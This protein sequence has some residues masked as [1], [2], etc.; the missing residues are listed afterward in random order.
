MTLRMPGR[1]Y[2]GV[3]PP[4]TDWEATLR[5]WIRR[6]V[7]ALAIEIGERNLFQ[8]EGLKAAASFVEGE[9][10]AAS[11]D[12]GR[13]A[14]QVQ[15]KTCYNLEAE[16]KGSRQLDEIVV[17][18]AHYDSV[19]GSPGANDNATGVAALLALARV[20]KGSHPERTVRFVA[21]ANEEPPFFQT[22]SMGSV[23]YASRCRARH[24]N[25]V[26][27]LSLESTGYYSEEPRSQH[28]P[29]PFGLCYPS[30]GDFIGFVGNASSRKPVRKV[31]G[32]F[33]RYAKYPSEGGA[34]PG[35]I[36]GVG[37]SDQ[38]AFWL[39]RYAALMVTDTALFRDPLYHTPH[40]TP[41]RLSYDRV[42]RVV[43][44]LERVIGELIEGRPTSGDVSCSE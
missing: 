9:L 21:F 44:G 39:E 29:F 41:E 22:P 14:F 13:Q 2:R 20:F 17:I 15:G 24:E 5:D 37:W 42:A 30:T 32:L 4:L 8:Y 12:V 3:M 25:I 33:R 10:R 16:I 34:L 1:S 38:W 31:V 26:A 27:M 18:G 40:D 23:V 43:A 36:P 7:E 28:Y 35:F 6:D 19:F 11:Y